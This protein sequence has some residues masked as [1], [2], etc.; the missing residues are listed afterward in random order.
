MDYKLINCKPVP[1]RLYD[2]LV[3]LGLGKDITL[4]SAL[5]TVDAVAFAKRN[6]CS[7]SSQ[8]ELW[9]G[10]VARRPGFNPANPPGRST[11]ELRNDGVAYPGPAGLPLAYYKVGL[12]TSN[13]ALLCERARKRGW[14]CTLTYPGN[15]REGHH[16]NFRKEP[17]IF[18]FKV[19]KRGARGPRVAAFTRSLVYLGYL[20]KE[21]TDGTGHFG[22]KVEAALKE[23]QADWPNLHPDGDYGIHTARQ[24]KATVRARKRCRANVLKDVKKIKDRKRR[25]RE[26]DQRLEACSKKYGPARNRR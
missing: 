14:T 2:E 23:F 1:A 16:T 4:N 20:R 10:W 12:D 7:L 8:Q 5:R 26:R 18:V 22:A 24:L 21:G 15:P 25:I 11:H 3:A 19:L 17:K 13:A 9:D 6:G